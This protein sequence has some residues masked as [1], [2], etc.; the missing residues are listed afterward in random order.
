M[1][2]GF[3]VVRQITA[4]HARRVIV[5]STW[6]DANADSDQRPTPRYW[7][8][9]KYLAS[10]AHPLHLGLYGENYGLEYTTAAY[11]YKGAVWEMPWR[12][13]LR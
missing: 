11:F 4:T 10:I 9:V 1:Q 7:S 13:N 2:H 3:D 12:S 6:L 5:T 8:R